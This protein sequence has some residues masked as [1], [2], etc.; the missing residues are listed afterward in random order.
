[1]ERLLLTIEDWFAA[2]SEHLAA[3]ARADCRLEGWFKGELLVLL[4]FAR[5]EGDALELAGVNE[6]AAPVAHKCA[7]C[8][9]LS[10]ARTVDDD[11]RSGRGQ[12]RSP[13]FRRD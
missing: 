4:K 1:M 2:K 6:R 5:V 8:Q 3:F 9:R 11:F 12:V 7:R 10:A 13:L